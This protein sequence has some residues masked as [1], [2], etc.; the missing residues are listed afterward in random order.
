MRA[1]GLA[2]AL[3]LSLLGTGAVAA[4]EEEIAILG[5]GC[6]WCIEADLEKVPGVRD[7]VSGY[8]GGPPQTANY[9]AVSSGRSG[10][11]EVVE[12]RFDP[13]VISYA[14]L[15]ERYWREID[16]LFENRQFC[17]RGPQYRTVIYTTSEAQHATALASRE[18]LDASGRLPGPVK[19]EVVRAG[20]FYA[21]ED[22]HQDYAKKNPLRYRYYRTSCGRDARLKA[23]WGEPAD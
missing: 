17:D 3:L 14:Q 10:H 9:E 13:T 5:G 1:R 12:V 18:A 7:V 16:P 22:Y 6:F 20:P 2:A 23:L 11:V 21:A 15:L 19:T 4:A 8:S